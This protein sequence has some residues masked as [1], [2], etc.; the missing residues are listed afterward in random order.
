MPTTP[1]RRRSVSMRDY[2][3]IAIAL[4][5]REMERSN[6][7]YSFTITGVLGQI[8]RGEIPPIPQK[9][10]DAG[11]VRAKLEREERAKN[12]KPPI[13]AKELEPDS[14]DLRPGGGI[15]TF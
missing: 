13:E 4:Y 9:L 7:G 15:F 8:M 10:L 1:G 3:Y 11:K 12:P 14:E 5:K 6:A 2:E